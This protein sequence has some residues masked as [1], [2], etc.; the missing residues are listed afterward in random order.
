MK[1]DSKLT[2]DLVPSTCWFSNVRSEVSKEDW[3]KIRR[4]T[5]KK[6][7]YKCE[8]CGGK[9]EKHPV[10]CHEIF[11][12]N[13]DT[14]LQTLASLIALCPSCHR[15]KHF[16]LWQLKGKEE[17]CIEHMM[18]VNGWTRQQVKQHVAESFKE[19]DERSRYDWDLDLTLLRDKYG[20]D[21]S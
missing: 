4:D 7:K 13:D 21:F 20:I 3:D 2:I 9:G 5:Y 1:S 16:G 12:Y 19:W 11:H 15:C 14:K 6:A 17:D 18:K 8:I 10:E